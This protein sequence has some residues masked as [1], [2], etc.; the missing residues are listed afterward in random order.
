MLQYYDRLSLY[1][2]LHV[3]S[4]KFSLEEAWVSSKLC[5]K[6]EK[7]F[8]DGDDEGWHKPKFVTNTPNNG[9]TYLRLNIERLIKFHIPLFFSQKGFY[10]NL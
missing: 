5:S 3:V 4:F 10:S 9:K 8:S 7:I 2:N 1:I 6:I